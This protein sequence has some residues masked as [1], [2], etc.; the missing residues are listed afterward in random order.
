MPWPINSRSESWRCDWPAMPSATTA[1]SSASTAPRTAIAAAVGSSS[2]ARGMLTHANVG[3]GS[4]A[5]SAPYFVDTGKFAADE[6]RFAA[7][8]AYYRT[9]P[10]LVGSEYFVEK[11]DAVS[12]EGV[13]NREIDSGDWI[14]HPQDSGSRCKAEQVAVIAAGTLG[15]PQVSTG[16]PGQPVKLRLLPLLFNLELSGNCLWQKV[17]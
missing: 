3:S 5:G 4:E 15:P 8:E 12:G 7:L 6:S 13:R 10:L 17:E 14:A 11:V 1:A 9:G 2:I 16:E